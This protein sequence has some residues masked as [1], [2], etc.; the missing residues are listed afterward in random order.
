[1][2]LILWL[3]RMEA[4]LGGS[5]NL[6]SGYRDSHLVT[7]ERACLESPLNVTTAADK[8]V[9]TTVYPDTYNP[10]CDPDHIDVPHSYTVIGN[11][12][13]DAA[14]FTKSLN[15]GKTRD[16]D[17]QH[18]KQEVGNDLGQGYKVAAHTMG[19]DPCWVGMKDLKD[20]TIEVTGFA[21]NRKMGKLCMAKGVS[22]TD[23]ITWVGWKII[24]DIS[25]LDTSKELEGRTRLVSPCGDSERAML[26]QRLL[27]LTDLPFCKPGTAFDSASDGT[28]IWTTS[29]E[30]RVMLENE[31]RLI[32]QMISIFYHWQEWRSEC[33][34]KMV[35]KS[36]LTEEEVA[37]H[38]D[39]CSISIAHDIDKDLFQLAPKPIDIEEDLEY[40]TEAHRFCVSG[41]DLSLCALLCGNINWDHFHKMGRH[42][43]IY[44]NGYDVYECCPYMP[45]DRMM[46]QVDMSEHFSYVEIMSTYGVLGHM[47]IAKSGVAICEDRNST[48]LGDACRKE[49]DGIPTV[50]WSDAGN[51]HLR[52]EHFSHA[53]H[54]AAPFGCVV[55]RAGG[56]LNP[57]DPHSF[58][59]A[60]G[61]FSQAGATVRNAERAYQKLGETLHNSSSK[62][63]GKGMVAA[64]LAAAGEYVVDGQQE[65]MDEV[66][67]A[68]K[69]VG[70]TG[71]LT[72]EKISG[73]LNN[74]EAATSFFGRNES[75][76]TVKYVCY[77]LIGVGACAIIDINPDMYDIDINKTKLQ[78]KSNGPSVQL[79]Y[80]E[81]SKNMI[82]YCLINTLREKPLRRLELMN[83]DPERTASVFATR[84]RTVPEPE[85]T[86]AI[87]P[88]TPLSYETMGVLEWVEHCRGNWN[89]SNEIVYKDSDK[90]GWNIRLE[91]K[92]NQIRCDFYLKNQQYVDVLPGNGISSIKQLGL[93]LQWELVGFGEHVRPE[94][95]NRNFKGRNTLPAVMMPPPP[96]PPSRVP[97]MPPSRVPLVPSIDAEQPDHAQPAA[98][99]PRQVNRGT[100][101]LLTA[102]E[103]LI[104]RWD[105]EV[106]PQCY[107]TL[108]FKA[109]NLSD[110]NVTPA[111]QLNLFLKENHNRTDLTETEVKAIQLIRVVAVMPAMACI[112]EDTVDKAR[113]V[114]KVLYPEPPVMA[115]VS[116]P[117]PSSSSTPL[118]GPNIEDLDKVEEGQIRE[119]VAH[120]PPN[121][122]FCTS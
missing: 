34:T 43:A 22:D 46:T 56:V 85:P 35:E 119:A 17:Q 78:Q 57:Y 110:A 99:S 118:N 58:S 64:M 45:A 23:Q 77:D 14:D 50:E 59:T 100:K 38:Y 92:R 117:G 71:R 6:N 114:I 113:S 55:R 60:S 63:S 79:L 2:S 86:S 120:L 44:I 84:D 87:V 26:L 102:T 93:F 54:R 89:G 13:L 116:E 80:R 3:R 103:L 29:R 106:S 61:P 28:Y 121:K 36:G 66:F 91:I 90:R 105:Q 75:G 108:G 96:V 40:V 52:C 32:K 62:I 27:F 49:R 112:K 21:V 82:M 72:I 101:R 104:Q 24:L 19:G 122:R 9:S 88:R 16:T 8:V 20:G 98:E 41:S 94:G 1:M 18:G 42:V 83:S 12:Y 70:P 30:R 5:V 76:E 97:L 15:L 74:K 47:R 51:A 39:A 7:L 73:L 107:P 115:E 31:D 67:G 53:M 25:D 68:L 81:V 65:K 95:L 48:L 33:I 4:L 111:L 11:T 109:G 69:N 10:L 37:Q